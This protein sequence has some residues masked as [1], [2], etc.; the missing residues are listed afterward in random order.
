M[1]E[2]DYVQFFEQRTGKAKSKTEF[3]TRPTGLGN[4]HRRNEEHRR[5]IKR[6]SSGKIRDRQHPSCMRTHI[7][8]QTLN[9][10]MP[11]LRLQVDIT[12]IFYIIFTVHFLTNHRLHTNKMLYIF[13]FYSSTP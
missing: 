2:D 10:E 13:T 6:R 12:S 5:K 8:T 7:H 1:K 9:S 4:T 11:Y 3:K